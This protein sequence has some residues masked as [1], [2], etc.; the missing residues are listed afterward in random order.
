MGTLSAMV[1]EGIVQINLGTELDLV[2][3]QKNVSGDVTLYGGIE[4]N[5]IILLDVIT[6][7]LYLN[8]CIGGEVI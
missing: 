8:L 1:Q 4:N 5:G 7:H 3:P 6:H 2:I